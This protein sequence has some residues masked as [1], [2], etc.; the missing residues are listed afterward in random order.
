MCS[1]WVG[2]RGGTVGDI[3]RD[4]LLGNLLQGLE[5]AVE[6]QRIP[7]RES[8]LA[9]EGLGCS[10]FPRGPPGDLQPPSGLLAIV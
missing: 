6:G 4:L 8:L 7:P 2:P 9:R 1:L 3:R 10:S 5:G